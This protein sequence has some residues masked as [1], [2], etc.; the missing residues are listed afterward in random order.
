MRRTTVA[1]LFL[2]AVDAAP[3]AR[4]VPLDSQPERLTALGKVWLTAKFSHPRV[5]LTG[6]DWD[7]TL[8]DAWPRL[9]AASDDKSFAEAVDAMLATIGDPVTGVR[10]GAATAPEPGSQPGP[11]TPLIRRIGTG[12]SEAVVIAL[13]TSSASAPGNPASLLKLIEGNIETL[14]SARRILLDMRGVSPG[15][16]PSQTFSPLNDLLIS[17]PVTLPARRYVTHNGYRPQAGGA[18]FY[19]S[20]QSTDAATIVKPRAGFGP[21]QVTVLADSRA[22]LP[23]IALALQ[24]SGS[25]SI[26]STGGVP[27]GSVSVETVPLGGGQVATIRVADLVIAGRRV[28]PRVDATIASGTDDEQTWSRALEADAALKGRTTIGSGSQR[29]PGAD[30]ENP[31]PTWEPDARYAD[32]PYPS[33]PLRLIAA[34]RLWGVIDYFFPYK[35][36]LDRPWDSVLQEFA[37]RVLA[38]KD[39]LEYGQVLSEMAARTNDSHVNVSGNAALLKWMGEAR[40]RSASD[41]WKGSQW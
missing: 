8:V 28:D 13:K 26:V 14:K 7:Q 33:E 30:V 19:S 9:K 11:A 34:Y 5:A 35:H 10:S 39:E 12:E 25:A 31:Q 36:L 18:S 17:V 20:Q 6:R 32:T 37:P 29:S 3:A 2:L 1:L 16:L 24:A 21:R 22:A 40:F 27:A 4:P 23:P 15:T 41:S 38:A